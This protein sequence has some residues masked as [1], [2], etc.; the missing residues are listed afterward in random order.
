MMAKEA[1]ISASS[2]QRIWR[3][4]GSLIVS[5][6]SSSRTPQLYP[7]GEGRLAE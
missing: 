3:A 6:S 4:H 1:G 5:G 2:V 7:S